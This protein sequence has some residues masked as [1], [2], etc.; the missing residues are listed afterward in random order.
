MKIRR[1]LLAPLALSLILPAAASAQ[2]MITNGG[3]ESGLTGWTVANQ[4]D[5]N[6]D[7]FSTA[8]VESPLSFFAIPGPQAGSLYA[9]TDQTGPGSHMLFQTFTIGGPVSS[10]TLSFWHFIQNSAVAASGAQNDLNYTSDPNQHVQ[11]DLLSGDISGNPFGGTVIG[12]FFFGGTDF[13]WTNY[14][15]DI[16]ALLSTP[17]TYSLRFAEVDNQSFFQYGVDNVSLA[18]NTVP[19]PGTYALV[20]VGMLALAGVKRRTRKA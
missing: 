18:V 14:S 4:A 16:T 19:E 17:G 7:W 11:V 20:A 9:V 8:G 2:Q 5:G 3:F 10:A 12:N 13:G 1:K 15:Q 6:G